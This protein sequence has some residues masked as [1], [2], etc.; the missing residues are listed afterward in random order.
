MK[1]HTWKLEEIRDMEEF[2]QG[3]CIACGALRDCCEPDARRYECDQCG[4]RAV[5]GTDELALMGYIETADTPASRKAKTQKTE[6]DPAQ[7]L[8][9]IMGD[10]W[11]R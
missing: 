8:T 6:R 11:K 9:E 3:G 1:T 2:Q 4:K 10:W 5:F 7:M